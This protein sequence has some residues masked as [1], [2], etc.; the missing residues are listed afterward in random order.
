[1]KIDLEFEWDHGPDITLTVFTRWRTH[2][3]GLY[4]SAPQVLGG[5]PDNLADYDYGEPDLQG[6]S[7]D[8]LHWED[9]GYTPPQ[10]PPLRKTSPWY[11]PRSEPPFER[12][13]NR[14]E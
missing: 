3:L 14:P 4:W 5:K 1:M 2:I 8:D 9:I 12:K 7:L 6:N 11:T 10:A 13:E